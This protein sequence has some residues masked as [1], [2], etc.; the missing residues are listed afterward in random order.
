MVAGAAACL[1]PPVG[2]LDSPAM[3][4]PT[5]SVESIREPSERDGSAEG[6]GDR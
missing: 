3:S 1:Q 6:E 4:E 2:L 5:H